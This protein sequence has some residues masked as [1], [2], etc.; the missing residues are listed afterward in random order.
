MWTIS[1][2]VLDCWLYGLAFHLVEY[3]NGKWRD[4]WPGGENAPLEIIGIKCSC[5]MVGGTY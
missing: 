1:G 3:L 2:S 4:S 5:G